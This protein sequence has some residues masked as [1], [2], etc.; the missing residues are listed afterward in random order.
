VPAFEALADLPKL[1]D[2]K[3]QLLRMMAADQIVGYR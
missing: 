2:N 1:P 3:S